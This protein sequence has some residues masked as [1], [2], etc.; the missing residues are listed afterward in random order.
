M[1]LGAV[2]LAEAPLAG[3][4]LTLDPLTEYRLTG[5]GVQ[6][7]LTGTGTQLARLTGTG[8]QQTLTGTGSAR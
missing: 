7:T 8:T 6:Q 5:S 2:A 1:T 4:V 3:D